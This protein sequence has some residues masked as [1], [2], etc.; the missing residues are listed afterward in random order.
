MPE[1]QTKALSLIAAYGFGADHG[2]ATE[3]AEIRS[4]AIEGMSLAA[5]TEL[6][7]ILQNGRDH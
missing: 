2:L 3:I 6:C 4:M 1:E 5:T 7:L